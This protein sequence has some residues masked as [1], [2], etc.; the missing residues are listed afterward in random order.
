[1]DKN[2]KIKIDFIMDLDALK[3][4]RLLTS[5]LK[6]Y[7]ILMNLWKIMSSCSDTYYLKPMLKRKM[8]YI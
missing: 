5:G 2:N 3:I 6:N 1:M 4:W 7:R 8:L